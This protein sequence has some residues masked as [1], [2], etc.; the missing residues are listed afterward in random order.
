MSLTSDPKTEFY[1]GESMENPIILKE[2]LI[3]LQFISKSTGS[4]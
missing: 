3:K 1:F 2:A 4:T